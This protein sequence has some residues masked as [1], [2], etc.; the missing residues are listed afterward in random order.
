MRPFGAITSRVDDV[1][2]RV[3]QVGDDLSEGIRIATIAIA[4]AVVL[5]AVAIVVALT[6]AD[7]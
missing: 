6:V 2:T 5:S 3:E 1:T 4:F 7:D